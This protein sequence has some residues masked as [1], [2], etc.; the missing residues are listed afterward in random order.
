M[1]GF[2]AWCFREAIAAGRS[3]RATARSP[4]DRRPR[5]V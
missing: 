5:N 4:W 1:A 2:G 3:A